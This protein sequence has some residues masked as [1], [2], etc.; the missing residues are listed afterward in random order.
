MGL[1]LLTTAEL[2]L[3]T[4]ILLILLATPLA[5]WLARSRRW[6]K[7]AIGALTAL[8][9]VLPPTVIGFYVLIALGP[10]SP[11]MA[12]L[13]PFGV[14]TLAFTF[15]GLV[16][17]SLF[18]SLPFAIQPLRTAFEAIGDRPLEIAATMGAG[19]FDRFFTVALPL[20]RRG[21]LSA[22]ILVF[23]HTVGEFGVVLMIGGNIP[24]K[25]EVLST[26]IYQLVESLQFGEAHRIAAVL[27]AFSF[28]ALLALL[29]VERRIGTPQP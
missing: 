2:A 3:V 11:L 9:L 19:P 25:T 21:F 15:T 27:V 8:P 29:L 12:L 23:A 13:Q 1:V 26:R 7:E 16:I 5:W 10:E 24:G 18:Y 4:T 22:S 17:G 20:A 14:R 28:A 6:W